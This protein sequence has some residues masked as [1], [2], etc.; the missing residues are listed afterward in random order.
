MAVLDAEDFELSTS[1]RTQT[2]LNSDAVKAL[3]DELLMRG[4][5]TEGDVKECFKDIS[6]TVVSTSRKDKSKAEKFVPPNLANATA[7]GVVDMLGSV[8]EKMKLLEKEEGVYKV[9]LEQNYLTPLKDKAKEA[10]KVEGGIKGID[11]DGI[12][13]WANKAQL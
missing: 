13:D 11:E 9:W 4:V 6:F 3:L 10:S 8:R 7:I 1:D 12:P 2:R 5:I